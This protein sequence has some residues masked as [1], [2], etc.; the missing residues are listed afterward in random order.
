[1]FGWIAYVRKNRLLAR[2]EE[3]EDRINLLQD[4]VVRRENA[5]S[6]RALRASRRD[7]GDAALIA[8]AG[9][10]LAEAKQ[11]KSSGMPSG[12]SAGKPSKMDLYKQANSH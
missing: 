1:M 7:S 11:D 9:S 8:E 10:I 12:R 4:R 3:L 6:M 2:V 5:E